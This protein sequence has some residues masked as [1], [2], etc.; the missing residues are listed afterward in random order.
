MA[1][2]S[3]DPTIG[4]FAASNLSGRPSRQVFT[5]KR[6]LVAHLPWARTDRLQQLHFLLCL[7]CVFSNLGN[8]LFAQS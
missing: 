8:L 7:L 2:P 6:N 5:T 3:C 1:D 4:C